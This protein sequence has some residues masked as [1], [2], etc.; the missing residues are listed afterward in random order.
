MRSTSVLYESFSCVCLIVSDEPVLLNF[1]FVSVFE[2]V[3]LFI[4]FVGMA[5]GN[6]SC[7][8]TG[9]PSVNKCLN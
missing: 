2:N 4:F 5:L 7:N 1:V 9:L 3:V 8:L 6:K